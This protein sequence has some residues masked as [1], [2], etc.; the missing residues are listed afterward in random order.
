MLAPHRIHTREICCDTLENGT[1][2][3]ERVYCSMQFALR[4]NKIQK[5]D[6]FEIAI[7]EEAGKEAEKPEIK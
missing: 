1:T 7:E 5:N 2:F 6:L 4:E 3:I